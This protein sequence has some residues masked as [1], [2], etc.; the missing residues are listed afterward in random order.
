M[1]Q[2]KAWN[3]YEVALL[4]ECYINVTQHNHDL[5][6]ELVRLSEELRAM[7]I[8]AGEQIDDVYRNL[9]GMH[10]QYGL[11]KATF[12]KVDYSSR[13]P[14]QL[15]IQIANLYKTNRSEFDKLLK[16]A[17]RLSGKTEKRL[18]TQEEVQ[19]KF[20]DW[21]IGKDTKKYSTKECVE[22]ISRVSDYAVSHHLLKVDAWLIT[23]YHIFNRIRVNLSGNRIFKFT[24]PGLF[25]ALEKIGKL[26]SDF[27]REMYEVK[28]EPIIEKPQPTAIV[29]EKEEVGLTEYGDEN[30][31]EKQDDEKTITIVDEQ[32]TNLDVEDGSDSIDFATWLVNVKQLAV[33]TSRMYM[34]SLSYA[35]EYA[36]REGLI[37]ESLLSIDSS[38]L[39]EAVERILNDERF[40]A[41]NIEKHNRFSAALQAF[42]AYRLGGGVEYSVKPRKRNSAIEEDSQLS[43]FA[44]WLEQERGLASNTARSYVSSLGSANNYALEKGLIEDSIFDLDDSVLQQTIQTILDNT[45]FA[46]YNASQHNRFSASLQTYLIYRSGNSEGVIRRRRSKKEP[47][48]AAVFDE[49]V[50][51]NIANTITLHFSNGINVDNLIDRIRFK[52]FYQA[53][54]GIDIELSDDLL[55]EAIKSITIPFEKKYYI[56]SSEFRNEVLAWLK[57]IIEAENRIIY[58]ESL[59]GMKATE[60][61]LH[62]ILSVDM[63]AVVVKEIVLANKTTLPFINVKPGY[64]SIEIKDTEINIVSQEL[65]RVWGENTLQTI[66]EL[67]IKLPYIPEHKIRYSLSY[68]DLFKWNSKD[69]YAYEKYFVCSDDEIATIR[70]FVKEKCLAN[71]NVLMDEIPLDNIVVVNYELSTSAIYDFLYNRLRD[72][73]DR[74]ANMLSFYGESD[75]LEKQIANYCKGRRNCTLD[76]VCQIMNNAIGRIDVWRVIEHTNRYM[77]RINEDNFVSDDQLSFDVQAIDC[78]LDELVREECIGLKEIVTYIRFPQCG[79]SWNAFLLESYIRRFSAGYKYMSL[80]TNSRNVGAVVKKYNQDDY[81]TLMAKA[82]ARTP[83]PVEKAEVLSFLHDMG[84]LG[85]RSYKKIDELLLDIKKIKEGI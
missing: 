44:T 49:A 78:L 10:W 27:I 42:L 43:E 58:Y 35:N 63:L 14:S 68:S 83:L 6:E 20:A 24:H 21:L 48:A 45:E 36:L 13:G 46:E 37:K 30:A 3:K 70:S 26:F 56:V 12:E 84:Y 31:A 11:I 18:M 55:I 57:D 77:V 2:Q 17:Y 71:G 16:E 29:E 72:M 60:F 85:K 50:L 41:F 76:D 66:D 82:V 65:E 19:Q 15:F 52:Q 7:A 59:Y 8:H 81:H 80:S 39:K 67:T 28:E 51:A 1:A 22:C 9:N 61:E 33:N 23:D 69:T 73:V 32:S 40:A 5:E 74:K 64:I 38:L 54:N 4:V 79:F 25:K 62:G 53:D 75:D 34:S 47:S